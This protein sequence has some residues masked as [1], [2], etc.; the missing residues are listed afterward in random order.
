MP[1]ATM[2]RLC[3][4][5]LFAVLAFAAPALAADAHGHGEGGGGMLDKLEFKGE[6]R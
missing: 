5:A 6:L 3:A 1:S 4:L 2:S